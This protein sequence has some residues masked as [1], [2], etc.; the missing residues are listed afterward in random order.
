ML[1]LLI[2]LAF[3][4]VGAL[5]CGGSVVGNSSTTPGTYIVTVTGVSGAAT[6]TGTVTLN[7]Q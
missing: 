3:L 2:S 5:G 7:V 4:T 1:G 6:V